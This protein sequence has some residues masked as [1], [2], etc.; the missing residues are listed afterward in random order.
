MNDKKIQSFIIIDGLAYLASG[1]CVIKQSAFL[2]F[3]LPIKSPRAKKS[4]EI[5]Q[6]KLMS[7]NALR[8]SV[9]YENCGVE[10]LSLV[11]EGL[12]SINIGS[13]KELRVHAKIAKRSWP[14]NYLPKTAEE[15]GVHILGK[16]WSHSKQSPIKGRNNGTIFSR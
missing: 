14:S 4:V 12:S 9:V 6:N 13:A 3:V 1:V 10:E 16:P 5:L 2:A 11:C 7:G 15:F 8:F